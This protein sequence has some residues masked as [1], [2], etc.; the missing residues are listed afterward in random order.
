MCHDDL[1]QRLNVL[2]NGIAPI[3]GRDLALSF[4]HKAPTLRLLLEDP[5]ASVQ[6]LCERRN[7]YVAVLGVP[8]R[9]A[10]LAAS[11]S[12]HSR[13]PVHTF[14]EKLEHFVQK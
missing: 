1:A 3:L 8:P 5:Q 6:Q 11:E 7:V 13:L 12:S 9:P 2:L 14:K 4:V 10:L